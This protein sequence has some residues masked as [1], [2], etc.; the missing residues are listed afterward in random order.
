M[1]C[2]RD[3]LL[4]LAADKTGNGL[5]LDEL[6]RLHSVRMEADCFF[7]SVHKYAIPDYAIGGRMAYL[8]IYSAMTLL[9]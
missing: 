2:W 3:D 5:K 7:G 8:V 9:N 4:P 6:R 1:L